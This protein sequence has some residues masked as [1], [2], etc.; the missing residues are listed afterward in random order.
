M[1]EPAIS[2]HFNAQIQLTNH[3]EATQRIQACR[4]GQW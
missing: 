3:M 2:L 4:Y 1:H